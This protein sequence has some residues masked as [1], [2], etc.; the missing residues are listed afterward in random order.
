MNLHIL[1]NEWW[2]GLYNTQWIMEVNNGGEGA[3][4][5][6]V[7]KAVKLVKVFN[8][9]NFPESEAGRICTRIPTHYLKFWCSV[10]KMEYTNNSSYVWMPKHIG[11][12]KTYMCMTHELYKKRQCC[13]MFCMVPVAENTA[14]NI[15]YSDQ[16]LLRVNA[17]VCYMKSK[18]WLGKRIL[19]NQ[20][21]R[22]RIR[23]FYGYLNIAPP[24]QKHFSG[25]L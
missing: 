12:N 9:G 24:L 25:S 6:K 22:S 19:M 1:A 2:G 18:T 23:I 21:I 15:I 14:I 4:V 20:N 17:M 13:T 5:V 7:Q 8:K 3:V 16:G 10:F 11:V